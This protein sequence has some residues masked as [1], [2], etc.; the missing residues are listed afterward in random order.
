M[1]APQGDHSKDTEAHLACTTSDYPSVGRYSSK[2]RRTSQ[3]SCR[4]GGKGFVPIREIAQQSDRRTLRQENGAN[5]GVSET[6]GF[7]WQRVR[8]KRSHSLLFGFTPKEIGV[9]SEAIDGRAK[10]R[11]RFI[12]CD[13]RTSPRRPEVGKL[14][15]FVSGFGVVFRRREASIWS[16]AHLD[17]SG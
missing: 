10:P 13:R 12:K 9:D 3:T 14:Y 17:S 5:G 8:G 6:G 15:G 1:Q 11:D 2:M 7:L 16:P 4:R